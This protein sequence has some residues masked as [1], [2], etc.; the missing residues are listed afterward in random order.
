MPEDVARAVGADSPDDD[1][2]I[3]GK[4]CR[5]RPLSVK[6]LCEVERECLNQYKRNYLQTFRDNIDLIPGVDGVA[7]MQ[8]KMEEAAKWDTKSLPL[9]FGCDGRRVKVTPQILEWVKANY[10]VED[11]PAALASERDPETR[12]IARDNYFRRLITAAVDNGMISDELYTALVGEKPPKVKIPYVNWWI[13]G[14]M[15]GMIA[16]IWVAFRA[17]GVTKDEVASALGNNPAVLVQLS[18]E[19]E[20][21]S[22]PKANFG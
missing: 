9:K 15:D 13:T 1:V 12:R 16:F 8:E 20:R 4:P 14:S 10:G 21:L 11:N 7:F 3:A 6:E 22:V 18:R 2:I 19:L 5:I 17:N